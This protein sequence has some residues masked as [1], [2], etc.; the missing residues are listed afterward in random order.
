[1]YNGRLPSFMFCGQGKDLERQAS[2]IFV[3]E[4]AMARIFDLIYQTCPVP[5]S[6]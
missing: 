1:M 6:E 5:G 3:V 2:R 4:H